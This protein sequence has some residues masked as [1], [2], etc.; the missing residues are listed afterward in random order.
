MGLIVVIP[1][2]A[3]TY[4]LK[5]YHLFTQLMNR[6]Y[7]LLPQ[8]QMTYCGQSAVPKQIQNHEFKIHHRTS[9]RIF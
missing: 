8:H 9:E 4:M 1:T 3:F 7:Q 5:K 6:K 2:E